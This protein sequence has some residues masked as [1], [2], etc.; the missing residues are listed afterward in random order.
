MFSIAV[1]MVTHHGLFL[2]GL[3]KLM[4]TFSTLLWLCV[5]IITLSVFSGQFPE[6]YIYQSAWL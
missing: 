3:R 2:V 5:W 6:N 4:E 1:P